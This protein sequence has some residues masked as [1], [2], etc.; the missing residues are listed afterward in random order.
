MDR[1]IPALLV[2]AG[3]LLGAAAA[4]ETAPPAGTEDAGELVP[5]AAPEE[6]AIAAGEVHAWRVAAGDAPRL[7]TVGQR[8]IELVVAAPEAQGEGR[9]TVIA[10]ADRWGTILVLL[11]PPLAQGARIEVRPARPGTAPGKYTIALDPLGFD[12]VRRLAPAAAMDRAGRLAATDTPESRAQAEEAFG[13]AAAGWSDADDRRWEAEA[14]HSLAA[15]ERQRGD[16]KA[17][18]DNYAAA[19]DLWRTFGDD[20]RVASALNGSGLVS[21]DRGDQDGAKASF[22]SARDLWRRLGEPLDEAETANNLCLVALTGGDLRD[23]LTCFQEVLADFRRLGDQGDLAFAL[24]NLGGV[25]DALGEPDAAL[26]LYEQALALRRALDDLP[27]EAQTL[28]NLAVVHRTLGEWQEALRLYAQ[29]RVL[30]PRL[31]DLRQEAVQF[32]NLGYAY[33]SLGEPQRALGALGEALRLRR[34][35]GDRRGEAITLNNLGLAHRSLGELDAAL[36]RH[37]EAR[38]MAAE[39]GDARQEAV[40]RLRLGE[41]LVDAADPAGALAELGPA[42]EYF[43]TTG[44]PRGEVVALHLQGRALTAAGRPR[45]A[46]P[47]LTDALALRRTL[48]DRPGEVE[49]LCALAA[50]ERAAGRPEEARA[51]AEEA[52]AGVE[53]MRTGFVSPD[54]RAAFLAAQR[55]AYELLLDLL[56]DRHAAE[57]AAGFDRAA[58]AAS[59]RVH[60]RTLFDALYSGQSAGRELPA[61]LLDRRRSL[62]RRLSALTSQQLRASGDRAAALGREIDSLVA[63]LDG[64]VEAEIRR[65]DPGY[66]A[67]VDPPAS[68]PEGIAALLGPGTILAEY[69]LGDER[70]FLWTVGTGGL[71]SFVL[72]PRQEIEELARRV[73]QDLATV[74][75]GD[76]A[77]ADSTTALSEMLLRP[78]WSEFAGAERLVVVPDGALHALPFGA[79]PVPSPTDPSADAG[80]PLVESHEVTYLPSAATLVLERQLAGR[81]PAARRAAVLADPVFAVDDPRVAAL[82]TAGAPDPTAVGRDGTLVGDDVQPDFPRLP[83]SRVEA[84]AIAAL[85][86]AGEVWTVL[87]LAASREAA[88]SGALTPFRVV[89]FATHAVADTAKPE[90]T[91]LVLS[92]V[93]PDGRPRQGFVGLP[94]IYELDLAADLVVLSGCQTALGREVRGEGLM[95]LTRAFLDAGVP[96]VVASLWRVE[97]RATAELMSRFYRGLWRDG[98]TPAAALREAQR[99]LRRD[100][101]YRAPHAWAGFVLQGEWR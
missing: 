31:G 89:H 16:L 29:V 8:G 33:L 44:N 23:A 69:A 48:S 10:P 94:E 1:R 50:A 62:R 73:Y 64:G 101:R 5:G 45:D 92:Q 99:S 87:D 41:A 53:R 18:A 4:P 59:E 75:A 34:E 43:R 91:G 97:D 46:L 15:L 24:N 30:L 81:T 9:G 54:L 26:A 39:L 28:N 13:E 80:E 14:R 98:L 65:R 70:S 36:A 22:T 7:L 88:L 6:R 2:V 32:N 21:L 57:P 27:G 60:A 11:S 100:P 61:E 3:S 12:D 68:T 55:R 17:A 71:R 20:R 79:L 76:D 93:G 77:K 85:A 19:L 72:P 78:A 74:V 38:G 51:H 35:T 96:R 49:T 83:F 56:M 37:R 63:E 42:A 52:V 67:A 66:A 86:P 58:L 47:P 82:V 40:S 90:R 25:H 95:G 84:E